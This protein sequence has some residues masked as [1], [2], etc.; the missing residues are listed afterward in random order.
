MALETASCAA[1]PLL[2]IGRRGCD[3]VD[4]GQ[5]WNMNRTIK[6]ARDRTLLPAVAQALEAMERRVLFAGAAFHA[7]SDYP[8]TG[9]ADFV[10][11]AHLNGDANLDMIVSS[12]A[13]S[14]LS[15]RL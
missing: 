6:A 5:G 8:V 11:L 4:T 13:G 10:T 3:G 14:L 1:R 12:Y 9:S 7:P 2:H 15:V